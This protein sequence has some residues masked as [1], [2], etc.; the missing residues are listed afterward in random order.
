MVKIREKRTENALASYCF[1][2][3]IRTGRRKSVKAQL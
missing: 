3:V 1:D 2:A